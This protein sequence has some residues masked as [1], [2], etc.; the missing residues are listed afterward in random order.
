MTVKVWVDARAFGKPLLILPSFNKLLGGVT[1]NRIDTKWVDFDK[2]KIT[3]LDG[4]CI[5]EFNA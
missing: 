4:V 2:A 1:L 3:L 5:G